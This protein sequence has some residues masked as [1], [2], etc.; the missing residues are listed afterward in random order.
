MS[1]E[2]AR[3]KATSPEDPNLDI[4]FMYNPTEVSFART[5]KWESKQGNRGKNLLPKVNFSGVEPYK[6]TLSGLLFDTYET[7]ESVMKCIKNI[8]DSVEAP[9]NAS[10]WRPP[11]YLFRWG[12]QEYY[13]CVVNSL[14]YKLT[15]FLADGTPVRAVV[16]I[17]LQEVEKNNHVG[18]PRTD[19]TGASRVAGL[20]SKLGQ[21]EPPA[22]RLANAR[23]YKRSR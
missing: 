22:A 2:K 3:L 12:S 20:S 19:S 21:A 14:T 6:F 15:M 9:E 1:L 5:V 16:D 13:H 18:T 17:A 4:V 10:D 11:V 7:K 8:K 23:S